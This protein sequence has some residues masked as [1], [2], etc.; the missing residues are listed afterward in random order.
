M[1]EDFSYPLHKRAIILCYYEVDMQMAV[2]S[3]VTGCVYFI[4]TGYPSKEEVS[5]CVKPM[6]FYHQSTVSDD[7]Q[8]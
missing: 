5:C 4:C 6:L 1:Q 3:D 8:T 7:G 2:V